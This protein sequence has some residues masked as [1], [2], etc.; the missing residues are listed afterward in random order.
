MFW[1]LVVVGEWDV[2]VKGVDEGCDLGFE[3]FEFGWKEWD[4]SFV[5]FELVVGEVLFV[6][7]E[8]LYGELV[9]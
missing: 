8:V 4:V 3:I 2:E 5:E 7:D 1:F 6:V 9:L